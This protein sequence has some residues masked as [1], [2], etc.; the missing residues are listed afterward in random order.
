[1]NIALLKDGDSGKSVDS[2]SR[3][4]RHFKLFSILA[5]LET[6]SKEYSI[7]ILKQCIGDEGLRILNY[8][9]DEYINDMQ[10]IMAELDIR[11]S[12][13]INDLFVCFKLHQRQR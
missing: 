2:W 13:Q 4:K 1:M 12:K 8:T 5:E 11:S 7:V 6:K 9:V 3:W 10:T